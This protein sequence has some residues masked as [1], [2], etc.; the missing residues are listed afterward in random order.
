M[1]V[2]RAPECVGPVLDLLRMKRAFGTVAGAIKAVVVTQNATA[3]DVTPGLAS[4][5]VVPAG[6]N[7]RD[8]IRIGCARFGAPFRSRQSRRVVRIRHPAF[9]N[10]GIS[11]TELAVAAA[12]APGTGAKTRRGS[13]L[14]LG[15]PCY[16]KSA[17]QSKS[18]P[19]V[20]E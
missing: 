14:R 2:V 18:L 8:A 17:K 7:A 12:A 15:Q 10:T 13:G 1:Q 16:T 4:A 6:A 3:T 20:A 9:L 19:L 11:P 5:R